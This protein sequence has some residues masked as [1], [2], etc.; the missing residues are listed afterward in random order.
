MLDVAGCGLYVG[1][2]LDV[3]EYGEVEGYAVVGAGW[4]YVM[5]GV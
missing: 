2:L 4:T 3:E 1:M 5:V